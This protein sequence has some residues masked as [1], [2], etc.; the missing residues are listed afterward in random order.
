MPVCQYSNKMCLSI[1]LSHVTKIDTVCIGMELLYSI[2]YEWM[3]K[4]GDQHQAN[5]ALGW[6]KGIG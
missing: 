3:E 4:I 6:Q 1:Y 5:V 2:L